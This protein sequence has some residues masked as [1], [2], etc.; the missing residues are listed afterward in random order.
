MATYRSK[1]GETEVDHSEEDLPGMTENPVSYH[2]EKEMDRD[3]EELAQDLKQARNG[4]LDHRSAPWNTEH[5]EKVYFTTGGQSRYEYQL[6]PETA[7]GKIF[8][9]FSAAS[10]TCEAHDIR[11]TASELIEAMAAPADQA[12]SKFRDPNPDAEF[13]DSIPSLVEE[14]AKRLAGCQEDGYV[15]LLQG[16][17]RMFIGAMEQL[18]E[19]SADAHLLESNPDFRP[20]FIETLRESN[21]EL[22]Q[23]L[24]SVMTMDASHPNPSWM[25]GENAATSRDEIY[26]AKNRVIDLNS[27]NTAHSSARYNWEIGSDVAEHITQPAATHIDAFGQIGGDQHP[28][29]PSKISI[30]EYL[31]DRLTTIQ[32]MIQFGFQSLDKNT[33]DQAMENLQKLQEDTDLARTAET[34]QGEQ[35]NGLRFNDPKLERLV[36]A[37]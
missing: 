26:D 1:Y 35:D 9:T 22:A 20:S 32:S 34:L 21:P 15:A 30:T 33:Y 2:F 13:I 6:N 7:A 12:L 14:T 5:H 29:N 27:D 19:L 3:E 28:H 37:R 25:D 8:Y 17:E 31:I 10:L 4:T 24:R 23:E 18:Q 16:N 11:N 36:I